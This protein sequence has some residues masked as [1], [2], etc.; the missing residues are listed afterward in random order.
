MFTH[1]YRQSISYALASVLLG[2][3]LFAEAIVVDEAAPL[4]I[5]RRWM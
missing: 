1:L 5:S 2:N 3:T 4:S